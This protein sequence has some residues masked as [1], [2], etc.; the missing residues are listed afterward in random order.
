[1]NVYIYS[2]NLLSRFCQEN[3]TAPFLRTFSSQDNDHAVN[4]KHIDVDWDHNM[5]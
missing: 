5:H 1:M 3:K 4:M 2:I